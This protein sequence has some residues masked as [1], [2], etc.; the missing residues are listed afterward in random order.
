MKSKAI[1][2]L[3]VVNVLLLA[4]LCLRSLTPSASAQ[5]VRPSDYIM[6]PAEVVG[7]NNAVI[8]MIDT[9]AGML[10][11]RSMD[12][13]GRNLIDLGAP[14]ELGRMLNGR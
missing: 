9:R 10:N 12:T 4:S 14:I 5:A 1:W 3:A 11:A 6:I 8:F 7:G 13:Q 2:A